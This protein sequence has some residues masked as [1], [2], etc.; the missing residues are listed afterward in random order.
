MRRFSADGPAVDAHDRA[1]ADRRLERRPEMKFVRRVRTLLGGDDATEGRRGFGRG[2]HD[3]GRESEGE[4]NV[5]AYDGWLQAIARTDAAPWN[6]RS[7]RGHAP[8][9]R[10]PRSYARSVLRN[11]SQSRMP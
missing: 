3:S 11:S 5:V 1:D 4:S 10:Y 8:A 2:Y 9:A 7:Q 6:H